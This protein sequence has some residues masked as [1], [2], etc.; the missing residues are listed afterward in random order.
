MGLVFAPAGVGSRLLTNLIEGN[1]LPVEFQD[2]LEG[3][4]R[5]DR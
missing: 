4:P 1:E 5:E 2:L 3:R